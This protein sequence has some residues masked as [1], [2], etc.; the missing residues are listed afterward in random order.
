MCFAE[1]SE[2]REVCPAKNVHKR[3]CLKARANYTSPKKLVSIPLVLCW[4]WSPAAID[5]RDF[6]NAMIGT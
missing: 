5:M 3:A 6:D 1:R 2:T 4:F